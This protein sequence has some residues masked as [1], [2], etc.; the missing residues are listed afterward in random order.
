MT[1]I[2]RI[3]RIEAEARGVW[4]Q[5]GVKSSDREFLD[6]L[7]RRPP[8]SL[9]SRQEAWLADIERRVFGDDNKETA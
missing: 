2:E 6:G 8:S 7:R 3:K 5:C 4:A 1:I 9:T